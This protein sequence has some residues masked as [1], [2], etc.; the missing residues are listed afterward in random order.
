MFDFMRRRLGFKTWTQHSETDADRQHRQE[1][2]E[3]QRRIASRLRF[4]DAELRS[5]DD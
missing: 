3:R 1:L 4:L 5:H 2:A